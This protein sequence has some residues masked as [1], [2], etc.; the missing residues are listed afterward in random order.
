[1]VSQPR[2]NEHILLDFTLR[3]ERVSDGVVVV[4]RLRIH[5]GSGLVMIFAANLESATSK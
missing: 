3:G 2:R 1:M 4:F 5:R